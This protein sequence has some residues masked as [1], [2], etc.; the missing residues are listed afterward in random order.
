MVRSAQ[1]W[2]AAGQDRR[3]EPNR[4]RIPPYSKH[5]LVFRHQLRSGT[6]NGSTPRSNNF[7]IVLQ[8]TSRI[9][10]P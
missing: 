5:R 7:K 8:Q 1:S 2:S 3:Q 4:K 6:T 10:H 9:G